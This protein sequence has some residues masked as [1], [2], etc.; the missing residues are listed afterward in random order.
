MSDQE[1][2][3][4]I[5][6]YLC[7][8]ASAEHLAE[9]ECA[10]LASVETRELFWD[11]V[12]WHQRVRRF[13]ER[14][15]V[16]ELATE[17]AGA[18]DEPAFARGNEA[19]AGEQP[20][21]E[22]LP[23]EPAPV[24]SPV[25]GFLGGVVSYVTHSRMLMFWLMFATLA[26]IFTVHFGG[27]LLS[28]IRDQNVQVVDGGAARHPNAVV[29]SANVPAGTI[30]ARLSGAVDCKWKIGAA[31]DGTKAD[32]EADASVPVVGTE[33]NAGRQLN[34]LA[35]LAEITFDSGA[36]VIL[37][38]PARFEV[39]SAVA[40]NLQVGKLA[41]KVP[42]SA[43]GFTIDTPGGKV[44]DLGTE[45]GVKVGD[46]RTTRVVVFV[47]QVAVSSSSGASGSGNSQQITSAVR[48]SAG[49][50]IVVASAVALQKNSRA[51]RTIRSRAGAAGRQDGSRDCLRRIHAQAETGGLVPDGR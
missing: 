31:A 18:A 48:V 41:A 30:V 1:L 25:L 51:R 38:A 8:E 6:D 24:A 36:K 9:L 26:G 5:D 11:R 3:Q 4:L 29:H 22:S 46:D 14:R 37:H 21:V 47:G 49:E 12:R 50:A 2:I 10:I 17:L 33:F 7:G 20:P 40:G 15:N 39:T 27:L 16:S 23:A 35:G 43:T 45:F 19:S 42:H 32:Y 28:R 34:L 44:V 13:F